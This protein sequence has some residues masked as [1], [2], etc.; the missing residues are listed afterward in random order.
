MNYEALAPL[1]RGVGT[2][3]ILAGTVI[4]Y[5]AAH[6]EINAARLRG[7]GQV[8]APASGKEPSE[9]TAASKNS[10]GGTND[11]SMAEEVV[12]NPW[13][14]LLGLLGA[15]TVSASFYVEYLARRRPNA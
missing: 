9:V 4:G 7:Q 1:L 14:E 10:S 3:L 8:A 2:S 13:F 15:A 11:E 12:E 6:Q 5:V